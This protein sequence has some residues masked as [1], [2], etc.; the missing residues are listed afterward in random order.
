MRGITGLEWLMHLHKKLPHSNQR[1]GKTQLSTQNEIFQWISCLCVLG[2]GKPYHCI[3]K[4]DSEHWVTSSIQQTVTLIGPVTPINQ[5]SHTVRATISQQNPTGILKEEKPTKIPGWQT[6]PRAAP[7]EFMIFSDHTP[8]FKQS[9]FTL[10]SLGFDA[11]CSAW[12]QAA[13]NSILGA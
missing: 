5:H 3:H 11:L 4:Q 2:R 7:N 13:P 9:P 1:T 12:E 6:C 8:N 10:L